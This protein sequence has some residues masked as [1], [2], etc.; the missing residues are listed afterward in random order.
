MIKLI[1]MIILAEFVHVMIMVHSGRALSRRSLAL[2]AAGYMPLT[3]LL[4]PT[5]D[6]C[7]YGE[8]RAEWLEACRQL[9]YKKP[10]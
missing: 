8:T 1:K 10:P 9:W 7:G 3:C 4:S 6:F 2:T 5:Q